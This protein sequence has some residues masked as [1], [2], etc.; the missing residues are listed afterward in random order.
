MYIH[1]HT[2]TH[3]HTY[4]YI[5]TFIPVIKE[6]AHIYHY[7]IHGFDD[8]KKDEEPNEGDTDDES[9]TDDSD[10]DSE[11]SASESPVNKRKPQAG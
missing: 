6:L 2:Y 11:D 3:T 1:I 7:Y 4:T 9:S 5:H 8:L 10:T